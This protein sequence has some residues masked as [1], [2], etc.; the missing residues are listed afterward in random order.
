[1]K[2]VFTGSFEIIG[3]WNIFPYFLF[4]GISFHRNWA[5][6]FHMWPGP[7]ISPFLFSRIRGVYS[8]RVSW[9]GHLNKSFKK[10]TILVVPLSVIRKDSELTYTRFAHCFP[11]GWE[12]VHNKI[13][14][15]YVL[16]LACVSACVQLQSCEIECVFVYNFVIACVLKDQYVNTKIA[17]IIFTNILENSMNGK[18]QNGIFFTRK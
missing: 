13:L 7:L 8:N 12:K 2:V 1:M 6:T 5:L 4:S 17:D 3:R 14:C 11:F 18:A 10:H 15:A 9:R 16:S